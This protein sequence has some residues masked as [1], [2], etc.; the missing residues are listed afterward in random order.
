MDNINLNAPLEEELFWMDEDKEGLYES[1]YLLT[2]EQLL[3]DTKNAT[4]YDDLET[5]LKASDGTEK[6][7]V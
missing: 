4:W 5:W 7:P 2:K 3:E 6:I 1:G